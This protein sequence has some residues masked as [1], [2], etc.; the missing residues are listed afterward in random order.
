MILYALVFVLLFLS[1]VGNT[2]RV[3]STKITIF[4]SEDFFRVSGFFFYILNICVIFLLFHFLNLENFLNVNWLSEYLKHN[5]FLF[6]FYYS[7]RIT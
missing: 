6:I 7:F 5:E 4:L 2:V 1:F 3:S